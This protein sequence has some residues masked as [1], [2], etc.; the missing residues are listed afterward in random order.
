MFC[1]GMEVFRVAFSHAS[2]ASHAH[3]GFTVTDSAG[4]S[5]ALLLPGSLGAAQ[6]ARYSMESLTSRLEGAAALLVC[7]LEGTEARI[8]GRFERNSAPEGDLVPLSPRYRRGTGGATLQVGPGRVYVNLRL[9][10]PSALTAADETKL[11]NRYV[12]PL[13]RAIGKVAAPTHY[14]GR[15][16]LSCASAPVASVAFAHDARSK[17]SVIEAVVSV[18]APFAPSMT[19]ASFLG[20]TPTT[21]DAVVGTK[22]DPDAFCEQVSRA[23]AEAYGLTF[24]PHREPFAFPPA[25]PLAAEGPWHATVEEAIGTVGASFSDSH[26]RIGGAFMA[27]EDALAELEGRLSALSPAAHVDDFVADAS[28]VFGAPGVTL[29]GVRSLTSLADVAFEARARSL[30]EGTS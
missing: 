29:F 3:H 4:K 11:L 16:W 8:L 22:R 9:R 30:R 14:F 27:S 21:I 10:D 23:Y 1:G 5:V 18:S 15:D 2:R 17:R 19:S 13:L 12:R 24:A 7:P 6:V 20:K 25:E 26:V 28:A